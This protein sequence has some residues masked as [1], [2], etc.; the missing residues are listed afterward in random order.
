MTAPSA[1]TYTSASSTIASGRMPLRPSRVTGPPSSDTIASSDVGRAPCQIA[2]TTCL[3]VG[4]PDGPE[5]VDLALGGVGDGEL[6]QLAAGDADAREPVRGRA[7][8]DHD[9]SSLVVQ[10]APLFAA[11]LGDGH[12]RAAVEPDLLVRTSVGLEREPLAVGRKQRLGAVGRARNR[13]ALE[14]VHAAQIEDGLSSRLTNR[15]DRSRSVGRDRGR[16]GTRPERPARCRCRCRGIGPWAPESQPAGAGAAMAA[17][18]SAATVA[19]ASPT[20]TGS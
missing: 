7:G 1:W 8:A 3:A 9:S 13:M 4:R 14:L 19:T 11:A 17:R 10:S 2:N 15:V 16:P 20:V 18:P 12:R 6:R 5:V